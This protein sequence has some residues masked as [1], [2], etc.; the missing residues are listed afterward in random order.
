MLTSL[1]NFWDN[2]KGWFKYSETILIA[3]AQVFFG[4][5]IAAVSN[6]DWTALSD[7]ASYKQSMWLAIGLVLNG[8]LTELA[9]R[10]NAAL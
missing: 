10:R 7:F 9:R 5:I 6:V 1:S 4:F 3:R 2:V 8:A